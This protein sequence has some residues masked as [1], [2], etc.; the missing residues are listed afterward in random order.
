MAKFTIAVKQSRNKYT[1]Y[2]Q[3]AEWCDGME[4]FF[5]LS[6]YQKAVLKRYTN[7]ICSG[8]KK[9]LIDRHDVYELVFHFY[10][11]G[12]FIN[13]NRCVDLI[14]AEIHDNIYLFLEA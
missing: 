9:F 2:V 8:Q 5:H 1:V 7:G 12:D 4:M 6:S 14:Y 11:A 13:L 10:R 3:R